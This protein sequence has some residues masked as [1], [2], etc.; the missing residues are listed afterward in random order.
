MATQPGGG[1]AGGQNCRQM[2]FTTFLKSHL[3][4]Q[5]LPHHHMLRRRW[6]EGVWRVNWRVV[7]PIRR[8]GCQGKDYQKMECNWEKET[9]GIGYLVFTFEE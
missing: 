6:R 3:Q 2:L 5:T 4:M 1:K 9:N 7:L 8:G